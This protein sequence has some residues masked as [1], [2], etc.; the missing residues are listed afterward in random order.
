MMMKFL[1]IIIVFLSIVSSSH[2]Q[3]VALNN[4]VLKIKMALKAFGVES[5]DI[6]SIDAFIDF[7]TDSS[8]CVKSFYHPDKKGGTYSLTKQEIKIIK[9]LIEKINLST[10]KKTYVYN[11]SDQPRSIITI[12]TT[13]QNFVFDDYGLNGGFPLQELYKIVY[14]L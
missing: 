5:D 1:L 2:S 11:V 7:T 10:V 6:P 8:I 4:P 14:K 12:T 3:E 9:E 13:T